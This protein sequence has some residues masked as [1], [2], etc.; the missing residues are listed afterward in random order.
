VRGFGSA[1]ICAY[2]LIIFHAFEESRIDFPGGEVSRMGWDGMGWD[3]MGWDEMRCYV[4]L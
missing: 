4:M 1:Y 2:L 3:G